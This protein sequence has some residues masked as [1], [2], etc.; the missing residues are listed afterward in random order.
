MRKRL[1][2]VPALALAVLAIV[3]G[4]MAAFQPAVA[5]G[6]TCA[7]KHC[8]AG[9]HCC[10]GCTGSPICVRIGFLCPECAPQ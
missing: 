9:T 3:F 6:S 10:L 1:I 8:P 7:T 2:S 5:G 4:S